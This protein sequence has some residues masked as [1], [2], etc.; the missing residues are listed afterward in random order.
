[1]RNEVRRCPRCG[2]LYKGYPAL[3]RKD[4]KTEI[5]PECGTAE[6]FERFLGTEYTGDKYWSDD[7]DESLLSEAPAKSNGVYSLR[8][9]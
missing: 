1:M 7:V 9:G 6:A 4:N 5:C 2:R 3:S 8:D